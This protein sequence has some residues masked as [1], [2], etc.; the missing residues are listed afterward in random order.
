MKH[1]KRLLA[2]CLA[3]IM[4]CS[5]PVWV[6]AEGETPSPEYIT[7]YKAKLWGEL[8]RL[9]YSMPEDYKNYYSEILSLPRDE[10]A[11][12]KVTNTEWFPHGNEAVV[13][14]EGFARTRTPE[15]NENGYYRVIA[16]AYLCAMI[17]CRDNG[18]PIGYDTFIKKHLAYDFDDVGSEKHPDEIKTI[19][20]VYL[21]LPKD[22]DA[23]KHRVILFWYITN[24]DEND[25]VSISEPV[26]VSFTY[27]TTAGTGDV[28]GDGR[29]NLADVS[30]M[31]KYIA[32]WNMQS[33][34]YNFD[35]GN[36]DF[37][38]SLNAFDCSIALK[39][40]AGWRTPTYWPY[41]L[42][43]LADEEGK[44]HESRKRSYLYYDD[45]IED[46]LIDF[47]ELHLTDDEGITLT[48]NYIKR[49]VFD[50]RCRGFSYDEIYSHYMGL[51]KRICTVID[52]T[53][54]EF[55]QF[56]YDCYNAEWYK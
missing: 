10:E 44:K 52:Y 37:S 9:S 17:L 14:I 31:L 8:S 33:K 29:L 4:M 5:V 15:F 34:N 13:S 47:R 41:S 22:F 2:M 50:N 38:S 3:V 46:W 55:S 53:T 19:D 23:E 16:G 20:N 27:E 42:I 48:T 11:Y 25:N 40:I 49:N 18:T 7:E 51:S 39:K 28:N 43:K 54:E 32:K 12:V 35:K 45:D 6:S 24:Y 1:V 36:L 30:L 56:L 21:L 26:E